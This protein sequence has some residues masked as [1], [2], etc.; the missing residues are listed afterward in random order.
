[1]IG[2]VGVCA[3]SEKLVANK[4]RTEAGRLDLDILV[5]G[6]GLRFGGD[7]LRYAENYGDIRLRTVNSL[8][9]A[10][11]CLLPRDGK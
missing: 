7:G 3:K 6:L 4:S 1:M 5:L 8:L 9:S 10:D 11:I 2:G